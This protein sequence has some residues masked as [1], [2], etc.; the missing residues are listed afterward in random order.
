MLAFIHQ[1]G[2]QQIHYVDLEAPKTDSRFPTAGFSK[3]AVDDLA[4]L[5]FWSENQ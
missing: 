4:R 1:A 5:P 3:T 2:I